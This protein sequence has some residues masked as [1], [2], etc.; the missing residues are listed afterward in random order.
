MLLL[1]NQELPP[2]E[3]LANLFDFEMPELRPQQLLQI[4]RFDRVL[5]DVL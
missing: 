5:V 3:L 1:L 2:S 4:Q